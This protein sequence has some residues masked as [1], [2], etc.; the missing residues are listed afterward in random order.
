MVEA[1]SSARALTPRRT[2]LVS[3]A[4]AGVLVALK[5]GVGLATGSLGLIS[6]GIESSGDVVAAV[7]TFFAVRLGARPADP[8]HPYGHRRA[9]NLGALGEAGI[10]VVGGVLV[11]VEAIG[12]LLGTGSSLTTAWYQ[13]AVLGVALAVDC[14]RTAVSLRAARRFDSAALRSNG[15]HFVADLAG[16]LAVLAGLLAARAGFP[17]GDS[18]A[19]L[20]VAAIILATAT[21]L[22]GENANVLMDRTPERARAAAERAIAGLGADIELN[23]L[24]VR[25]SAGRYFADV[26][27]SVPPGRAVV[28]GHQAADMVES[29]VEGALPGSDVVVHVEPRHGGLD[30]RERVLAIALAEPLVTEAH[31]ITIIEQDGAVSVSLHLKFPADLDLRAAHDVAERVERAIRVRLG[32]ADAQ[33][34]L[35]PLERTLAARQPDRASDLQAEREVQRVVGARPGVEPVGVRLLS[36]EAGRVLFLTLKMP[37]GGS[38]A[39]AHA[40]AGELEEELRQCV[41]GIADVVV[42]TEP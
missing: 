26:V 27:V 28:E 1:S 29:A 9:E 17:E 13:F 41:H 19:A 33:T 25:E 24:R 23:R 42:H 32:V 14:S 16:S 11:S 7:V 34:H 4:A 37:R 18:I 35:E 21:R 39:A 10:L 20:F 2:T 30:L 3:I 12:R 40:L 8:E 15:L 36:T 6:A 31:D 5:L 38:L 22:I